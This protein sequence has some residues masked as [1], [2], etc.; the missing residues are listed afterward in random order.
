LSS[1]QLATKITKEI[2][3]RIIIKSYY[4]FLSLLWA[5]LNKPFLFYAQCQLLDPT[6]TAMSA[7]LLL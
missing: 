1:A 5:A 3:R 4:L 6:K 7:S 2:E